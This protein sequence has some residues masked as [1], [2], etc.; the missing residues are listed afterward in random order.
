M[1]DGKWLMDHRGTDH[2]PLAI[3][4]TADADRNGPPAPLGD[5]GDRHAEF[6]AAERYPRLRRVTCVGQPNDARES[7]VAALDQVKARLAARPARRLFA[8]N[9]HAIAF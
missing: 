6:A 2:Q 5:F 3:S 7:A 4:R 1:A 9:Q 8:R